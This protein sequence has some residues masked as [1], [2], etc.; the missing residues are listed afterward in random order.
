M[1]QLTKEFVETIERHG[2]AGHRYSLT[3]WELLQLAR[4][5]LELNAAPQESRAST[6]QEA[7]RVA[8]AA[9]APHW[10]DCPLTHCQEF[11]KC[12]DAD[13]C[14]AAA[15][16]CECPCKDDCDEAGECLKAMG[17]GCGGSWL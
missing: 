12:M 10:S 8:P 17:M 6:S 1:G 4:A 2:I 7:S 15:A 9:A 11:K 14:Q 5:W 13:G 3:S 16:P